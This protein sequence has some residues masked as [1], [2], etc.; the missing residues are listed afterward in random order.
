MENDHASLALYGNCPLTI[1]CRKRSNRKHTGQSNIE[2]TKPKTGEY[3]HEEIHFRVGT[4][5]YWPVKSFFETMMSADFS[6]VAANQQLE[7]VFYDEDG[8]ILSVCK[9]HY[10][11]KETAS[12]N[13]YPIEWDQYKCAHCSAPGK[14]DC[15]AAR[16]KWQH[17][18]VVATAVHQHGEGMIHAHLR[19]GSKGFKDLMNNPAYNLWWPTIALYGKTTSE[20][21]AADVLASP[22]EFAFMLPACAAA[23]PN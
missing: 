12:W 17:K 8:S 23:N 22:G 1:F 10:L 5:Y 20:V 6:A 14:K 2:P 21:M 19:Y 11:G 18:Y 7:F 3:D 9:Y 4:H 16:F 13:G 15:S